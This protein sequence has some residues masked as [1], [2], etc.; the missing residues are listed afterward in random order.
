MR[1]AH[2]PV[3]SVVLTIHNAWPLHQGARV[4]A[5]ATFLSCT[6]MHNAGR[7]QTPELHSDARCQTPEL[8]ARCCIECELNRLRRGSRNLRS[9]GK[10]LSVR[11]LPAL[12]GEAGPASQLAASGRGSIGAFASA[13][14]TRARGPSPGWLR[15]LVACSLGF[16]A[17]ALEA[18]NLPPKGWTRHG[19]R[20][21]VIGY[22]AARGPTFYR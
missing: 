11:R 12:A 4:Q 3:S 2:G 9:Q 1:Y 8:L 10:S 17:G 19:Y 14:T 15:P 5:D 22:G 21:S 16:H 20:L 18:M 7:C 13:P 6:P